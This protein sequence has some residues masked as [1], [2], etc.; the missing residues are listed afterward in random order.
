MEHSETRTEDRLLNIQETLARIGQP[1]RTTL[2]R[3]VRAHRFPSPVQIGPRRIAFSE[4]AVLDW[5]RS[6]PFVVTA[7]HIGTAE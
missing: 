6:R 5:V 4:R 7:Q 1:S 3:W 2:W